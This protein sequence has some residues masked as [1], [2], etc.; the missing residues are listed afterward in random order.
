M[1]LQDLGIN[2]H[3]ILRD[4]LLRSFSGLIII[5]SKLLTRLIADNIKQKR[6]KQPPG[7]HKL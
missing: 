3:T 5:E 2:K 6:K 7:K 1:G 4:Q